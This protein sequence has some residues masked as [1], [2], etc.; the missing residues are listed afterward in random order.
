MSIEFFRQAHDDALYAFGEWTMFFLMWRVE[1]HKK[2]LVDRCETC[3]EDY[4]DIAEVFKQ[5]AKRKCPDCFGTTFEGGFKARIVR[6]AIWNLNAEE[7]KEQSRGEVI[8]NTASV[9]SSSDFMLRTG[10]YLVRGD[11]TRWQMRTPAPAFLREGFNTATPELNHMGSSFSQCDRE[12]EYSVAYT[13]PLSSNPAQT[14][15]DILTIRAHYLPD[16]SSYEV[17]RGSLF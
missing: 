2:G 7:N 5:S 6:P 11:N 3:Y 12:D 1:D 17:I 15:E 9:Q 4:G 14:A 8:K 13:L 16:F 10:D